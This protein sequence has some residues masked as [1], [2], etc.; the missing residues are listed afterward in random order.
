MHEV[1]IDEV[2]SPSPVHHNYSVIKGALLFGLT[3]HDLLIMLNTVC[4]LFDLVLTQAIP[5]EICTHSQK[6]GFDGHQDKQT[7]H[8][9]FTV[10]VSFQISQICCS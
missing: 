2:N 3:L 10:S 4:N 5:A 8:V 6:S 1:L 7:K 9:G